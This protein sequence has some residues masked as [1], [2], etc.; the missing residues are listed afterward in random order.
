MSLSDALALFVATLA[1]SLPTFAWLVLGVI[2]KRTGVLSQSLNE[3]LS[4]WSF[5]FCLP[6]MLFAGAAQ[7]DY[8][9]LG[10]ATYL[11]A[12]VLATL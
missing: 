5:N 2:L 4:H 11:L 9:S 1:I 12:G 8:S 7:V 6:L 10:S 3:R